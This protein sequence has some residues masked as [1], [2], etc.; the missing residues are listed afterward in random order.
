M[1]LAAR[2]FSWTPNPDGTVDGHYP[3]GDKNPSP[4]TANW[5]DLS[6]LISSIAQ[7][8]T[9][10]AF[11]QDVRQYLTGTGAATATL[12]VVN[13]SGDNAITEGWAISGDNLTHP[14]DNAGSGFLKLGATV[15]GNTVYSD[16]IAWSWFAAIT[17]TLAPCIPTGGSG[18]GGAG[19]VTFS[20]DV[21]GDP[22]DGTNAGAMSKVQLRISGATQEEVSVGA[23]LSPAWALTNI[24]SSTPSPTISQSGQ[25]WTLSGGGAG[26]QGLNDQFPFRHATFSGDFKISCKLTAFTNTFDQFGSCGLMVRETTTA[27]SKLF[28]VYA[29]ASSGTLQVKMRSTTDGS[30]TNQTSTASAV[31]LPVWFQ[32]ERS[33]DSF[34]ARYSTDG[35]TWNDF[36]TTP[37]LPMGSAVVAGIFINSKV[38][39]SA[40][41]GSITQ[42]WA[43]NVS[44]VTFTP[45]STSV[46][47][48]ATFR[49]KDA[50]TNLS[51][52]SPSVTATPIVTA[53]KKWN[54]GHGIKNGVDRAFSTS[55][56][57]SVNSSAHFKFLDGIV[58]WGR[59]EPTI[60]NY[61]WSA[62]DALL[63]Q[64]VAEGKKLVL[65]VS[66]KKFNTSSTTGLMP[67][68]MIGN[69]AYSNG[70]TVAGSGLCANMWLSSVM[71]AYIA[72]T[73][74]LA[75]RYDSNPDLEIVLGSEST[76]SLSSGNGYSRSA[77]ATQLKRLYVAA[78]AAFSHT[79]YTALINFLSGE[80][81]ELIE[82]AYQAGLGM[83]DPDAINSVAS[84]LF[85]GTNRSGETAAIRD[86][87]GL[88]PRYAIASGPT[89]GGKDDNG[90]PSNVINWAQANGVTHLSWINYQATPNTIA[91]IVTAIAADS[92]LNTSCPTIY[93][94]SC[95][96]S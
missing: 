76:P 75:A 9:G 58:T 80:V 55:E 22:H 82:A 56:I 7:R 20:C 86:Y 89:L 33:G 35:S 26:F 47:K 91:Q 42:L 11:S 2:V 41:S 53:Y 92:S 14:G 43:N 13:V 32:I 52:D 29:Q 85:K 16:P 64:A 62:V 84:D 17:D 34:T 72:M 49:A 31:S 79:V 70:Y 77:L 3:T 69:A 87:R 24:G 38:D 90:P 50:A 28:A 8:T 10:G 59:I 36:L 65:A 67:S 60:G 96:A 73:Q 81:T 30:A 4:A 21:P 37:S 66:W 39:G 19:T 6:N 15:S 94:G 23:G 93:G 12:S 25:D 48:T 63:A 46:A 88:M 44:R 27:G 78:G 54:P 18:T 51:A 95:Q 71:N 61:S 74:A 45:I 5:G 40:A 57:T 68:E 83:S 1:A